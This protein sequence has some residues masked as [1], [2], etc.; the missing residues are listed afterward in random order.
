MSRGIPV[1]EARVVILSQEIKNLLRVLA[2]VYHS[3]GFIEQ[4]NVSP[5]CQSRY[6]NNNNNRV[7]HSF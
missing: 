6:Y 1:G 2:P 5:T 7:H 3:H 4:S